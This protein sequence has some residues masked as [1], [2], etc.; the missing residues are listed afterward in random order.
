MLIYLASPY[1]HDDPKV[2]KER[3]KKVVAANAHL[4]M[5]GFSVYSPIVHGHSLVEHW[6]EHGEQRAGWDFWEKF[7]TLMIRKSDSFWVLT[8]EGWKESVG[9]TSELELANRLF[10]PIRYVDKD[11]NIKKES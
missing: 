7:D 1:S 2:R 11:F 5:Q 10:L 8:L 9:V 6:K 4:I 3:F